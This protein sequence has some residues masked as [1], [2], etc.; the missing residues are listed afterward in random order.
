MDPK[1]IYLWRQSKYSN[2]SE[3]IQHNLNLLVPAMK[4]CFPK[5]SNAK[6]PRNYGGFSLFFGKIHSPK[7][8][9]P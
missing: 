5:D 9:N 8:K 6:P 4:A 1:K 7:E 3:N 2:L